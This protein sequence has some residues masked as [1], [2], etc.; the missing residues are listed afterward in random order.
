[1]YFNKIEDF[2]FKQNLNQLSLLY[3]S[4]TQKSNWV[5]EQYFVLQYEIF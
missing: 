3:F 1:M 2:K 5:F 4:F